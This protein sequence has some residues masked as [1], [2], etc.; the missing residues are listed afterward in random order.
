MDNKTQHGYFVL[1]DISGYTSYVA[2]TEL[3]HSQAVLTELLELLVTRLTTLLTLHKIEGDAVFAYVPE[4]QLFRSETLL[5]LV[6]S[7]YVAFRDRV[8]GVVR[9]STCDCSACNAIS[10]LDLKFIIHHGDYIVQKVTGINELVGSDVNLIHRLAKNHVA[11]A[12]GW[13]A[14]LLVT[15]KCFQHFGMDATQ[16]HR[17]VESYEHLGEVVTYS[18][19]LHARYQELIDARHTAI[20]ATEADEVLSFEF[21]APPAVLWEWFNDPK[22][23]FA[24]ENLHIQPA[25]RP[26]GRTVMGASNHCVHGK[27]V[28]VEAILDWRPFEYFTVESIGRPFSIRMTFA[29]EPAPHGTRFQRFLQILLPLPK[30]M[31]RA[32]CKAMQSVYVERYQRLNRL[33]VSEQA[34]SAPT[35]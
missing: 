3:E 29:F 1:A 7:T 20:A 32:V 13:R 4:S 14:Y 18:S 23:R 22:K 12:T 28:T 6:E 34:E 17:Q 19:D 5:E 35:G 15:E 9:H 11:D 25:L 16:M 24:W 10:T 2:H 31:R 30:W 33:L 8:E 26:G 21:A 27:N